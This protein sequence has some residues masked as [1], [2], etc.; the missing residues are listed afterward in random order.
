MRIIGFNLT[1]ILIERK[2]DIQGQLKV[3]QNIDIKDVKKEKISI[4]ETEAIKIYFNFKIDYS[5]D[6]ANLNFEGNIL[7]LPDKE[8]MNKIIE[9]WED[10]KLPE[11]IRIG[12]FNFLMNKCNIKAL[13]LEDDMGLPYHI[14]MPK[15]T[16]ENMQT[17]QEEN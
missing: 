7:A 13:N 15:I 2:E 3:N 14:P 12:L 17:A 5:E 10:K 9:S 11:G 8:E 4:S 1:K 16:P 6:S